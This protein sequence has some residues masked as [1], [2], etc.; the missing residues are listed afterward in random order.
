MILWLQLGFG[1]S[2][3]GVWESGFGI[4]VACFVLG[5]PG[6]W[7]EFRV[8]GSRLRF[9]GCEFRNSGSGFWV[10]RFVR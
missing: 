4:G 3:L 8:S 10:P 2:G 9:P 7:F 1:V 5:I 6:F